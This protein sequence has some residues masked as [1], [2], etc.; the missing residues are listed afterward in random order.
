M[1]KLS[2]I[3]IQLVDKR[4]TGVDAFGRPV[5]SEVIVDVDNVLVGEPSSEEV[6]DVLNVTGKH[7]A[8]TLAIP[9]GDTH[10]WTDR[11]VRF[12]GER[13]KTIGKPTQGIDHLIPLEWNKKVKVELYE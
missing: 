11:E 7:L 1:S 2:G 10:I 8:Y 4:K 9:K 13:F 3:T 5:Y 6:I 12:F